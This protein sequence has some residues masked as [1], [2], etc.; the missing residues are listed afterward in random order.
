VRFNLNLDAKV[1]REKETIS[2]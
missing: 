2:S 1:H